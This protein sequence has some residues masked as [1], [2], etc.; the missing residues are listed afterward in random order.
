M[1]W[2]KMLTMIIVTSLLFTS[3]IM[4]I[5]YVVNP[6]GKYDS[7]T[8]PALVWTGRTDKA[9]ILKE[10]DTDPDLLVLGSSRS[11]KI[12]P[13]F[14]NKKTGMHAF[15]AG[16]NSAQAEDYYTMLRYSLE[17]LQEKP[18]YVILGID[19]EAFHNKAPIDDR[20][21]FNRS[22]AKYLQKEDRISTTDRLVS[23]LSYE[24][25]ASA[26]TSLYYAISDYPDPSTYYD[27]DGFLHY[28]NKKGKITESNYSSK[29]E[30]YIERYRERFTRYTHL[31]KK[32]KDYFQK[33]LDLAE[34][35]NI[36][37]IAFITTLHDDLIQDLQKT[38][39]YT[40]LKKE[41]ITFLNDMEQSYTLFSYEDFDQ[42]EKYNGS[43]TAFYD[44]AHI[45]E[46]NANRITEQLLQKN[47]L[48]K[49][50]H[51]ALHQ[52]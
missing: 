16:V 32:R 37:V 49:N 33:F 2:E 41:L 9:T 22:L 23:L 11:M 3:G 38:R 25:T 14:I 20:L 50:K 6:L 5:N 42:V 18:K 15:N 43:L 12:N 44:G 4:A 27:E 19:V 8:F 47:K 40:M 34:R 45:N 30:D 1:S 51:T 26:F 24:E 28:A 52:K 46:K 39:N 17:T 36:E 10:A 29:I 7:N 35:E 21:L 31:G 48:A 13:N